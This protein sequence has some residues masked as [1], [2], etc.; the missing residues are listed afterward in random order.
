LRKGKKLRSEAAGKL[1]G[2]LPVENDQ[3]FDRKT[4]GAEGGRREVPKN[5][6]EATKGHI[7]CQKRK[8]L[9]GFLNHATGR[10][11]EK[12]RIRGRRR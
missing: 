1:L 7:P 3:S 12:Q 2:L 8:Q 10:T 6:D 5:R 4:M 9:K 11:D